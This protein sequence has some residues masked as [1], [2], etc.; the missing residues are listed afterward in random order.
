MALSLQDQ[1]LNAGLA[2]KKKAKKIK[3]GIA[4]RAEDLKQ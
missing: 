4:V 1:L 2:D 3:K